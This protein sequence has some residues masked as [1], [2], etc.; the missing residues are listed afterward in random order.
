MMSDPDVDVVI[1]VHTER[2]PIARA[3]ASALAS[4]AAVRVTVVAHNI[5]RALIEANL[6]QVRVPPRSTVRVLERNDGIPSPAG[7][8]NH[9]LMAATAPYVA[10]LGSD[11]RLSSGAIDSWLALARSTGAG[12]VIACLAHADG[13]VV[14][15]PPTRP[16]RRRDLDAVGDR[17]SYR[18]ALLGLISRDALDRENLRFTEGLEVGED[19]AFVTRLWFSRERIAFDRRGPA[20]VIEDD[21]GDRIT[22]VTRSIAAELAFVHDVVGQAWFHALTRDQRGSACVKFL[23]IHVF[24]VVLN[25]EIDFWTAGERAALRETALVVLGAAPGCEAVL[26]RADRA[27]LD[28]IQNPRVPAQELLRLA[29]AR[30]RHGRPETLVPRAMHRV[31]AREAPLR[32]MVASVL[33]RIGW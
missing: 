26:S 6:S 32:L 22:Y 23:R 28:A 16:G 29:Q 4:E 27:L 3:V 1:A 8:F 25:R 13:T 31:F 17:L 10:V 5:D 30:R 21:A 15:T 18:S 24:G 33:V 9:G 11:D 2:R 19:V 14:P 12:A 20:Y 7:P